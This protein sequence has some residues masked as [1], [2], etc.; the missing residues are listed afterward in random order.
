MSWARYWATRA[1]ELLQAS[2][3]APLAARSWLR[4]LNSTPAAPPTDEA[5]G[6]GGLGAGGGAGRM[7]TGAGWAGAAARA[8]PGLAGAGVGVG[9]GASAS[10]RARSFGPAWRAL[11]KARLGG[12][13]GRID[14]ECVDR[15]PMIETVASASSGTLTADAILVTERDIQSPPCGPS[16]VIRGIL[17][18]S[19]PGSQAEARPKK[20]MAWLSLMSQPGCQAE[21]ATKKRTW[22]RSWPGRRAIIAR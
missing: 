19:Q 15:E 7:A 9:G 4:R 13:S 6:A 5:G 17:G 21:A 3:A 14:G 22:P 10:S 2:G 18:G 20:P 16:A 1:R 8:G 12:A 11:R